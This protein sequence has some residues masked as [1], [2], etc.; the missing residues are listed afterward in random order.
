MRVG[1]INLNS[2]DDDEHVQHIKVAEV[3]RHPLYKFTSRY[4]DIALL[5]LEK[6]V[7][8]DHVV[9]PACLFTDDLIEYEKLVA[10]GWGDTGF[11][12]KKSDILLKFTLAPVSLTDCKESYPGDRYLKQG[13]VEHQF[14]AF[15]TKMDT[16][17]VSGKEIQELNCLF[18]HPFLS[19]RFRWSSRSKVSF[20][21]Q[22]NTFC[23]WRYI[24]WSSLWLRNTRSLHKSCFFHSLD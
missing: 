13:L 24:I 10:T 5:K 15:D 9:C 20:R 16:C 7:S 6:P 19:G 18:K 14:C 1:D 21:S 12:E 23:C 3:I 11:G 17:S 22:T 2:E 4:N 8:V